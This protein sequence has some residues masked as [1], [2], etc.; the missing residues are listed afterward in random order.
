M[1]LCHRVKS[2]YPT[3]WFFA[4]VVDKIIRLPNNA[5]KRKYL[6]LFL[7]LE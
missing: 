4:K 7:L 3:K 2:R 1:G 6:F 5:M